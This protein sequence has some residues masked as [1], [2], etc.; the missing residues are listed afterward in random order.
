MIT[1]C[2]RR[3]KVM[4]SQVFVCPLG[5]GVGYPRYQVLSRG[6]VSLV[7][8]PLGGGVF[9]TQGVEATAAVGLHPSG[10]LSCLHNLV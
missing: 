2:Q 5:V 8:G 6:R 4:F 7:P 10:M 3:G 1:D 9:Y